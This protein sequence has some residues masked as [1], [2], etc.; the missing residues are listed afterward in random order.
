M[1]AK[2][3]DY[4]FDE[5][6]KVLWQKIRE[7]DETLTAKAPWKLTDK[8]EIE[9]VLSPIAQIILDIAYSLQ[10]FLPAT[11]EKLIAQFSQ[12]QVKK[13]DALFPRLG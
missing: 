3:Q 2:L 12:P 8:A 1:S 11:A 10:P 9:E 7:C 5:A 13:G 4:R 6:L